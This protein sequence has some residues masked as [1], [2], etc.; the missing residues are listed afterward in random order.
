MKIVEIYS[1]L[2]WSACYE[3]TK[4]DVFSLLFTQWVDLEYLTSFITKNQRFLKD[5]PFFSGY[6]LKEIIIEARREA[7]GLRNN[8]SQYYWNEINGEHP[9]FDDRFFVLNR[10][11]GFDDFKREMYGHPKSNWRMTSVLR[12]YAIKIPSENNAEPSAYIVTGG[13]IKLSN[14]MASMQE[15]KREYSKMESVQRW[16][17]IN[18]ITN[19]QQLIDYHTHGN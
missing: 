2:I 3:G 5:N 15:L 18:K 19:K 16:L 4:R 1:G 6:S 7:V 14:S 9:D 13:G 12:L 10:R 11:A 8:F 17:E